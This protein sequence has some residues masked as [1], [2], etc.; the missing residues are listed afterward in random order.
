MATSSIA[1]LPPQASAGLPR[2]ADLRRDFIWGVPTSSFQIEG[3]AQEV[4]RGPSIWDTYCR[5]GEIKN[6]DTGDG[7][8]N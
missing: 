8:L 1:P 5:N 2:I 4:G 6:K 3:A 7:S